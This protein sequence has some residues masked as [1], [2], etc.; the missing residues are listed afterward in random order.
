[1]IK[2]NSYILIFS[3]LIFLIILFV[4]T[5]PLIIKAILAI[6][7]IGFLF[8][9]FRTIMLKHK[10]R[11]LKVAFYSSLVFTIGL[12]F[13][14]ILM[15]DSFHFTGGEFLFIFIVLFY[16]L[17]GNFVYGLPVSALAEW[18]SMKFSTFRFWLS[19]LIH[20]GFGLATYF[21]AP[22]FSVPAIICSILFFAFDEITRKRIKAL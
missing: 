20:I 21:I 18:I 8:P 6:A 3:V 19:G 4:S 1:M 7:T 2:G 14:S 17:I 16:S 11:K 13:V 10:F 15:E 12:F 9:F 22:G 5:T